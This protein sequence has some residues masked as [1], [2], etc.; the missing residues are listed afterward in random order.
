[1]LGIRTPQHTFQ[2]ALMENKTNR[3]QW[4]SQPPPPPGSVARRLHHYT[5]LESMPL[6]K[7]NN[8]RNCTL[9]GQRNNCS[10]TS[11]GMR[12]TLRPS[13]PNSPC[14]RDMGSTG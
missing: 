7:H 1:M 14:R 13:P 5:K 9:L 12:S 6:R 10:Y 4:G 8:P 2:P 3:L 11:H